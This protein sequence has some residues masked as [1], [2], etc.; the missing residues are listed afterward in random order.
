MA[1]ETA[2]MQKAQSSLSQCKS[3]LNVFR[4]NNKSVDKIEAMEQVDTAL[5][6]DPMSNGS[7]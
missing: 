6:I 4:K 5:S 1:K 7:I 2:N 3:H